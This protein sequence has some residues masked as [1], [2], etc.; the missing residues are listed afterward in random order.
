MAKLGERADLTV[1]RETSVGLFLDTEGALGE[2]L[3]PRREMPKTWELGGRINVFLYCDSEDRPV[4]T[5]KQPLAMPGEFAYLEVLALTD[6]GAFVDWRLPKDLLVPFAEQKARLE[7]GRSYVVR[8]TVDEKSG[9]II[10]SRRLDRYLTVEDMN[11]QEGEEVDL[12]LFGKTELGFKAIVN[13]KHQ[14]ILFANEVFR[15]LRAGEQT[16]GYVTKIRDDGK[17]DLSLY[18]PG[19]ARVEELEQRI[20]IELA[21]RGGRWELCDKSPAEAIYS[22]LG[23]SKRSFKQATGALYRRKLIVIGE[24]AI[25]LVGKG[26]VQDAPV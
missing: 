12:I 7:V 16:R 25:R 8:V 4:A 24:N 15:R 1:L 14:G 19:R 17:L 26:P 22:A 23:V 6:V 21:R 10:G 20:L 5:L 11:Y 9:R 2:V 18:P 13:G 3:L